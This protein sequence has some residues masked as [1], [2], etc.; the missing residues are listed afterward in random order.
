MAKN[1]Q[2]SLFNAAQYQV[3]QRPQPAEAPADA[4]QVHNP[5]QFKMFMSAREITKTHEPLPGDRNQVWD[6]RYGGTGNGGWRFEKDHELWDRKTDESYYDREGAGS[7]LIDHIES[8][9]MPGH[10]SLTPSYHSTSTPEARHNTGRPTILGGHHRV[11]A[12]QELG[13][14]DELVPVVHFKNMGESRSGIGG[15][16]YS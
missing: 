7:S 5:D 14:G 12:M 2:R 11:A 16:R 1:P 9:G 4:P 13:R 6:S 3:K 10:I 8:H 15:F